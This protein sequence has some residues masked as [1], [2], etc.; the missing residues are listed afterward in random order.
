MTCCPRLIVNGSRE[1]AW[2][3]A[4]KRVPASVAQGNKHLAW[5]VTGEEVEGNTATVNVKYN[6]WGQYQEVTFGLINE[7]GDAWK[8]SLVNSSGYNY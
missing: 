1:R 8:I 4:G 3:E 7:E 6:Q 2:I 5:T